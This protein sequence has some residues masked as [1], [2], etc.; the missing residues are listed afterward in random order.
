MQVSSKWASRPTFIVSNATYV[1]HALLRRRLGHIGLR[2]ASTSIVTRQV[3]QAMRKLDT[4]SR[5]WIVLDDSQPSSL[6]DIQP[7]MSCWLGFGLAVN[8]RWIT[9]S[10]RT[11][12]KRRL[13]RWSSDDL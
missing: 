10:R 5:I 3:S 7:A 13:I 11:R 1:L 6:T 12:E 9:R 8:V 4:T 2:D